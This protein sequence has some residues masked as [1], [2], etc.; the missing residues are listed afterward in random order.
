MLRALP[1]ISEATVEALHDDYIDTPEQLVGKFLTMKYMSMTPK[2]HAELFWWYLHNCGIV[3]SERPALVEY[4][5]EKANQCFPG[6][7][8]PSVLAE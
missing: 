8:D 7:Y 4:V 3:P 1:F 2:R 6:M 5:G